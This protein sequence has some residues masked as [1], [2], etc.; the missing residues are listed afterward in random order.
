MLHDLDRTASQQIGLVT[1]DQLRELGW[2]ERQIERATA[3]GMIFRIR[4][5]VYRL[6]GAPVVWEQAVL[7]AILGACCRAVI[8]HATA[9]AVWQLLYSDRH[10][11]GI[12]ITAER[13]VR[14]KGVTT[15]HGRISDEEC[16]RHRGIPVTT[17]ERTIMDLAGVLTERQLAECVDDAL[18]RRLVRLKRLRDLVTRAAASRRGRRLLAPLHKVLA[19]RLPG[20]RP[21][22]SEF[23]TR[24]NAEWTRLGLP[25]AERQYRVKCG[26]NSYR[27]DLA[28]VDPKIGVEWD[29]FRHHGT[30]SGMDGD[31]DRVA[32]LTAEGWIIISFTWNTKPERIARAIERLW[33]D[34]MEATGTVTVG[35]PLPTSLATQGACPDSSRFP[36]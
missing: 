8:S 18:R 5:R 17:P 20:Y 36:A 10:T 28:L 35:L 29:S 1:Y 27:L 19:D 21:D 25:T 7:A 15:H 9:A 34:R 11:A 22:D 14:L 2:T 32:D 6:A 26:N 13:P 12:H 16:T 3:K 30:R 31:S 23:E 33:R 4:H 24:M